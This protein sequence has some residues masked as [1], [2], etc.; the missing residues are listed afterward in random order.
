MLWIS[1]SPVLGLGSEAPGREKG[2]ND[3]KGLAV[4]GSKTLLGE[5]SGT[6]LP[7]KTSW[8]QTAAEL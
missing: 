8:T 3:Q 6:T 7:S 4:E 2:E 5:H 1:D